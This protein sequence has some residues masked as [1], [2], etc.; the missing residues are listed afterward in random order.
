MWFSC[1]FINVLRVLYRQAALVPRP[2]CDDVPSLLRAINTSPV[3]FHGE[4]LVHETFR[5]MCRRCEPFILDQ[6]SI[7]TSGSLDMPS[8]Y[9][10][11]SCEIRDGRIQYAIVSGPLRCRD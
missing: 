8:P 9:N 7:H 11:H 1:R 3:E 2:W 5:G 4:I 10:S 6:L